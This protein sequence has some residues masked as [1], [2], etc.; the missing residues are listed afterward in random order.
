MAWTP[1]AP[2]PS[3]LFLRKEQRVNYHVE[4]IRDPVELEEW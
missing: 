3:V 4:R 2:G 1:S